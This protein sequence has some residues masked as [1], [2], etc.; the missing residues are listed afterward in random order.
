VSRHGVSGEIDLLSLDMDGVDYWI[1]KALTV[2]SPRVVILEFNAAWGPQRSVAIPYESDFR[3][4]YSR[5][6]LYCGASLPAFVN[7]GKQKGYR[8]VGAER[9]GINA[10]FLRSDVGAEYFPAQSAVDCFKQNLRLARWHAG[11]IPDTADRP[12]WRDV[13]EV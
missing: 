13:V 11:W 7:L 9:S 2:V 1:W 10:V 5:V 6:P 8:F 12:E 4:D 3:I